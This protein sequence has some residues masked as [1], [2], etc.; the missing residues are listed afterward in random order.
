MPFAARLS[1]QDGLD[2]AKT[3]M[4][5]NR[6]AEAVT[7]LDSLL[8]SMPDDPQVLYLSGCA[9][10]MLNAP[11]VAIPVLERAVSAR[12][13]SGRYHLALGQAYGL[14]A[15]GAGVLKAVSLAKKSR[16]E[17]EKAV[18]LDPKNIEARLQLIQYYLMAPGIMGGGRDKALGQIRPLMDLNPFYG[19]LMMAQY[20]WKGKEYSP[21]ETEFQ[22]L[23]KQYGDST[24]YAYWYNVYGYCLIEQ[25][26]TNDA[27]RAFTRQK[28]LMP[29]QANAYDSLG[30]GY[31]AA[32]RLEE[33][34]SEYRRALEID[35]G[36]KAAKAHLEE[37]EKKLKKS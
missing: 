2:R 25:K 6:A 31:R 34:A 10:L 30:D 14:K 37:T 8:K 1:G 22:W 3:L 29:G 26:R 28:D 21:A 15:M 16:K 20:H 13:D 32:G 27:I 9:H 19:H 4:R 7:V 17:F 5:L 35:P 11:E 33:A 24:R 18:Q 23:E 36:F 12:G